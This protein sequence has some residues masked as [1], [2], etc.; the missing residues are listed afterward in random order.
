MIISVANSIPV[1][2][3][4][5]RSYNGFGK[6]TQTAVNVVDRRAEPFPREKGKKWIA[7]PAM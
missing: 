2:R 7:N 5:S 3:W 1:Q 6:T 4:S